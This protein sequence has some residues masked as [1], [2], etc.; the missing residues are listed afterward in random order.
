M[1]KLLLLV[2]LL[3]SLLFGQYCEDATIQIN[4]DQY[5]SETS[6][7]I[8][9]TSG[10]VLFY[11]GSYAGTPFYQPQVYTLC[12]PVGPLEFTIFDLYG[13]GLAGSLWGGQDGSYYVVQCGDTLVDGSFANLFQQ[14][15]LHH[16]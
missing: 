16:Q 13:D 5:P 2:L 6:W 15:V 11:H 10:N 8:K 7:E 3:P 12:L 14:Y 4:L 1:K 9:D